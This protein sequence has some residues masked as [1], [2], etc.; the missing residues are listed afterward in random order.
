M[1]SLPENTAGITPVEDLFVYHIFGEP[2]ALR[3][4]QARPETYRLELKGLVASPRA[5]S[6]KDIREEFEPVSATVILQCMTR[7]H[8][9]RVDVKGARLL[10][11]INSAAPRPGALK[12]AIF[13]GEGFTTDLFLDEIRTE[14]GRFLLAYEMNGE[15]LTADHGFP[16]RVVAEG[17]Y[18]YKWCKWLTAIEI[19]DYDFKGHYEGRRRWSDKATRGEPVI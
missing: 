12:A 17:K 4:W 18:A 16:L 13:G 15:P 1:A 2:P 11:V 3:K 9:G 6:A 10:D 7:I 5:L 19:V 14:P 8:W